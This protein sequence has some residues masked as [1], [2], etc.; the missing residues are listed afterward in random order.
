VE[1]AENMT[2]I[3]WVTTFV[4]SFEYLMVAMAALRKP[5]KRN[6]KRKKK[7]TSRGIDLLESS[8]K[9]NRDCPQNCQ[10]KKRGWYC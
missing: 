8:E 4:T 1:T 2:A 9:I 3:T 6:G 5:Q 7:I 10:K